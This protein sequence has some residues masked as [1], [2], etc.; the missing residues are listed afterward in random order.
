MYVTL[1]TTWIF[2]G[3]VHVVGFGQQIRPPAPL[4]S[5][6]ECG[7]LIPNSQLAHFGVK[8]GFGHV[9]PEDLVFNRHNQQWAA[10][11]RFLAQSVT[12]QLARA[13]QS[14][15]YRASPLS[16]MHKALQFSF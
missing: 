10:K 14:R 8:R 15:I 16:P 2:N 1:A 13:A 7:N 11:S 9:R 3:R 5:L 4:S 6:L 12:D